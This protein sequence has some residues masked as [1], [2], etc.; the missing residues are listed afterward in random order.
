MK[1][2]LFVIAAFAMLVCN[3]SSTNAHSLGT[4]STAGGEQAHLRLWT[5]TAT[6]T[7]YTATFVV[8]HENEVFLEDVEGK[9]IAVPLRD[10][11]VAD[12]AFVDA[13]IRYIRQINGER[14]PSAIVPSAI[15][16][17]AEYFWQNLTAFRA[18][19][20]GASAV[21][22]VLFL[23]GIMR[24]TRHTRIG[25]RATVL[26]A[27]IV[28]LSSVL[29]LEAQTLA[30]S[31]TV[32]D[33]AFAPYKSATVKT[34]WD[35]TYFYVE[36]NG[37]PSHTM[38]VGITSW[39]QQVPTPQAYTGSNAWSIPL[40]PV[41]SSSPVSTKTSLYTGA[42]AIAVNSIPIFNALNNRGDD[43]FLFG[44]LDK[45]GGHCG[46]GDDYH[47]HTAPLHLQSTTGT[48]RPIAYALDGFAIWGSLE[49]DGSAMKTLDSYNGH[50][51]AD[52]VY[53]YHGTTTY[54]YTCGAMRGVVQ[55][56]GDQIIPQPR[57]TPI[58]P[59]LTPLAGAVI[60]ACTAI[61][62]NGYSLEYTINGKKG[63]VNY[64]WTNAGVY[65]FT[66]IDVN[67]ATTTATYRGAAINTS[68]R[69]GN[70]ESAPLVSFVQSP[71]PFTESVR[72]TFTTTTAIASGE[73][74]VYDLLGNIC[75]VQQLG[76][77]GAGNHTFEWNGKAAN[78][79]NAP[80]GV[81]FVSVFAAG[82]KLGNVQLVKA[83]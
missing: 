6:N 32:I 59:S 80:A 39:Q 69:E 60:T 8:A 16:P 55:V 19:I 22:S 70:M 82:Q 27:G 7:A 40:T 78:G 71:N 31:P 24:L 5:N 29:Y 52:G 53:H 15:A 46:K 73:A 48:Q 35:A 64:T 41:L 13:H 20:L 65:T 79:A 1:T 47:Y 18:S 30:T 26:C 36:S 17:F 56:Q 38:M 83:E 21:L 2:I 68:V 10:L 75:S 9:V 57:G 4:I 45:F 42:I 14:A 72:I 25:V 37:I 63:Y 23:L 43:A 51:G 58:R 74:R 54:P 50:T 44:E 12:R 81:Y 11:T 28:L 77:L 3:A 34:R 66:F 67:G 49:P 76:S 33:T 61:G 62:T